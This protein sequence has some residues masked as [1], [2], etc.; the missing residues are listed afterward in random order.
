VF[1]NSNVGNGSGAKRSGWQRG[2]SADV[3]LSL[4]AGMAETTL[5]GWA[6]INGASRRALLRGLRRETQ[7]GVRRASARTRRFVPAGVAAA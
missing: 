3:V 1:A 6:R 4:T 5:K 2:Y 7:N